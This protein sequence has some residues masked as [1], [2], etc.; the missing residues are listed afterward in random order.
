MPNKD[1]A[2]R[3][4]KIG[5]KVAFV[6]GGYSHLYLGRVVGFTPKG[7]RVETLTIVPVKSGGRRVPGEIFAVMTERV[8]KVGSID[9]EE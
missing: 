3:D 1:F 9:G 6:R 5:D 8:V 2:G 7:I 4:L